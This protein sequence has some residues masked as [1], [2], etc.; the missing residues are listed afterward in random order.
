MG[1]A[2]QDRALS[3]GVQLHR[4]AADVP[5]SGVELTGSSDG[6][7]LEDAEPPEEDSPEEEPPP[8]EETPEEELPEDNESPDQTI[9]SGEAPGQEEPRSF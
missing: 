4:V 7:A 8:E 6:E 1:V 5:E 2:V 3:L 9:P